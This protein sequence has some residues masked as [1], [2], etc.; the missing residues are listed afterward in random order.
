MVPAGYE[1][2]VSIP[3][4]LSWAFDPTD[5]RYLKAS[6]LHDWALDQGW[7]G[8]SSAASF[9]DALLAEK[10]GFARR[11]AMVFAVIAYKFV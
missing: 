9:S 11:W 10:V 7:D 6:A 2:D 4:A 8:V 5:P 3:R 1:F